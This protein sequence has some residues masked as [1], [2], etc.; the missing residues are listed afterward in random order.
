MD[1]PLRALERCASTNDELRRWAHTGAPHGAAV[2]SAA[3][4][5][6]RGRSGRRWHS[7]PGDGLYLSVLLRPSV[8]ASA[9]P[10]LS[11]VA[12]LACAEALDRFSPAPVQL[13]WPN[14]L[15]LGGK[16]LGGLLLEM[17]A[18]PAGACEFVIVGVGVNVATAAFPEEIAGIAT[19]LALAQ[20]GAPVPGLGAV[21]DA[22]WSSIVARAD[23]YAA[24]GLGP[25][26]DG[27]RQ[28]SST[29][30]KQVEVQQPGGVVRGRA[31][32]LDHDGALLVETPLG[33]LVRVVVGDVLP[34]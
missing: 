21:R 8:P 32:D 23:R 18:S 14:D 22:L 5:A 34:L 13:K 31:V 4:D 6:G 24:E 7:P 30:G 11:F 28:R 1:L 17:S 3:Q 20:P 26:L 33:Q 19:S 2:T 27:W 12:G 25:V 15:Q 9:A 10:G 16:K 29:L